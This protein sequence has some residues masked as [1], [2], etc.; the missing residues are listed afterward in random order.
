MKYF[1]KKLLLSG[2][3]LSVIG[4][5]VVGSADQV[6]AKTKAKT[7]VTKKA[8]KKVDYAKVQKQYV[9]DLKGLKTYSKRLRDRTS[10]FE[11]EMNGYVTYESPKMLKIK[12]DIKKE[13]LSISRLTAALDKKVDAAYKNVKTVNTSLEKVAF[14]KEISGL[15]EEYMKNQER[16]YKLNK[17]YGDY[18]IEVF[19]ELRISTTTF[20]MTYPEEVGVNG[21]P[22]D[23]DE[24]LYNY[25]TEQLLKKGREYA[26]QKLAEGYSQD[27]I[28][29]WYLTEFDDLVSHRSDTTYVD[30]L[31]LKD[32]HLKMYTDPLFERKL[33]VVKNNMGSYN[34]YVN[35]LKKRI[36]GMIERDMKKVA[37]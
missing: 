6:D 16:F 19:K 25:E 28:A 37:I 21:L 31:K 20:K 8:P 23:F 35:G 33:D 27:R 29:E 22:S 3:I 17:M 34:E 4:G 7:E 24:V 12:A 1:G 36:D 5:G 15:D 2:I 9:E 13:A 30:L 18:Y 26:N 14:D 11:K 10:E 32:G